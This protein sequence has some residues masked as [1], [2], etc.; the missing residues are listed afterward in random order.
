MP[1]HDLFAA[2]SQAIVWLLDELGLKHERAAEVLT[3][4]NRWSENVSRTQLE[5]D[6]EQR[7]A[8]R[9]QILHAL[10]TLVLE[11]L[12]R[13]FLV[14]GTLAPVLSLP[15]DTIP[16]LAAL[17]P[18]SRMA[19]ARN[20]LFV[21]REDDL[22]HLAAT[23]QGGG[24]AA[25]SQ[26][27]VATGLG[28]IGK[29]NLATEFVH[30]YGQFFAGGV[31]W[32]SFADTASVPSEIAA[33]GVGLG[34]SGF[35]GLK[36]EDQVA[37]VRQLWQQ[38]IPRLLIFDNCEDEALLDQWRPTSGGCRVLV[39]SRRA[40]WDVALGVQVLALGVLP[41]SESIALLRK[42]RPDL[43]ADDSDLAA[44]AA[45][46]GD[47]PLALHVAGSFLA[48]YRQAVTLKEYLVQLRS[49]ALLQHRSL[50]LAGISPTGHDHDVGRTFAVSYE[51]LDPSNTIDALALALLARV[52][53]F[54]PGEP[55]PCDLLLA[56]VELVGDDAAL[57]V[58][59]AL[60]R[61]IE[62]G[63]LEWAE[64][65]ALRLHRLLVVF[66]QAVAQ[67]A[68]AQAAVEQ[69]IYRV[70][71]QLNKVDLPA[72]LLAL[73]GHLRFVTD[74]AM[75]RD[76]ERAARLCNALGHYL[77]M[78]G[79]YYDAR[80]YLEGALVI[81]KKVLGEEHPD[82]ARSLNNLGSLLQ[83]MGDLSGARPYLEQALAIDRKV[84]G[85]ER[86]ETARRLNNLGSL[87]QDMGDLSGARAYYE[88]ALAIVRKVLGDEHPL[89]AA[90]LNN[91]GELLK[92]MGDLSGARAY[93][94]QAL[95]ICEQVL[96]PD[97]PNTQKA[98][99]N[100]AGLDAPPQTDVQQ[101]DAAD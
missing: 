46:L 83:D 11:T 95:R 40:R 60:V 7:R 84:L 53:Y 72:P 90:S 49:P 47:L 8:D 45:E 5:G 79:E 26:I 12:G 24:T 1:E 64:D 52:A 100:L 15:L 77:W 55:I 37:L 75:V 101:A 31:Y 86:R 20:P 54:A 88:Q 87:L 17:P 71:Y 22:K 66:V 38:P 93:Y 99:R 35:V 42:H 68:E 89:M 27:A 39:T 13:P 65:G 32:L 69:G 67:D 74:R 6:T 36:L 96:G 97:H 70:A 43:S 62:L 21:G 57:V 41:R 73:Q 28:G 82:T 92:D 85:E 29:T 19:L 48:R 2:T 44:L 50:R 58:E 76:D 91:L 98:R 23:L 16:D 30:R 25:I 78:I 63:L 59:D 4:Q 33:C 94:E 34:L 3:L 10:N 14:P 56:T 18:H 61:L 9:A 80:P 51:R 81:D